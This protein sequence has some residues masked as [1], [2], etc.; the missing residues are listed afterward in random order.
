MWS[1]LE[2]WQREGCPDLATHTAATQ[3]PYPCPITNVRWL[4]GD[5]SECVDK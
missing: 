4:G 2:N 3:T 1:L 5:H